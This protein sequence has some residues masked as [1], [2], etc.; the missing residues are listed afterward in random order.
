ME[1]DTQFFPKN[2]KSHFHL[3]GDNSK[4]STAKSNID[5]INERCGDEGYKKNPTCNFYRSNCAQKCR[6]KFEDD[7]DYFW[8]IDNRS[9]EDFKLIKDHKNTKE[10]REVITRMGVQKYFMLPL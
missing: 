5:K 1:N 7:V 8:D 2:H 3:F 10:F 4:Y 6:K 9:K